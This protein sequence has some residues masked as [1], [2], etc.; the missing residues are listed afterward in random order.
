MVIKPLGVLGGTG[1]SRIRRSNRGIVRISSICRVVG[2]S[3]LT[4]LHIVLVVKVSAQAPFPLGHYLLGFDW[5]RRIV[6]ILSTAFFIAFTENREM[7]GEYMNKY[8]VKKAIFTYLPSLQSPDCFTPISIASISN[9][10]LFYGV[11]LVI[12]C[13]HCSK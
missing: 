5:R 2:R 9:C 12:L 4:S 1:R 3:R 8:N 11:G 10:V 7:S 6:T 13:Q